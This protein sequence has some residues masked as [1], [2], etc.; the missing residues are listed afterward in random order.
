MEMLCIFQSSVFGSVF[1]AVFLT[2]SISTGF[3]FFAELIERT[4]VASSY[5]R[6]LGADTK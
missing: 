2:L 3:D 6:L 4:K 5:R 1:G